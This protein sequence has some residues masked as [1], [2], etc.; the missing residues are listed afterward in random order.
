MSVIMRIAD[1]QAEK[2]LTG[3][4]RRFKKNGESNV[5]PDCFTTKSANGTCNC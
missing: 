5:C 4:F 3:G 2:K 1:E